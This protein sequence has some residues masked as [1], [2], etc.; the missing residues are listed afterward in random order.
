M[1]RTD[2][3]F[4]FFYLYVVLGGVIFFI[5]GIYSGSFS[6]FSPEHCMTLFLIH[7]DAVNTKDVIVRS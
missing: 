4:A 7:K 6:A 2:S 3:F 5:R 1:C